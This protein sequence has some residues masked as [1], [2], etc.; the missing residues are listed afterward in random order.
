MR[1]GGHAAARRTRRPRRVWK[2]YVRIGPVID[3]EESALRAF[4]EDSFPLQSPMEITTRVRD[5]GPVF[6]P[7]QIFIVTSR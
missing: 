2:S 3:V 4:K 1:C 5:N 6:P 7:P